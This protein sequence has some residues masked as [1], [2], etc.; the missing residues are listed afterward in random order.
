MSVEHVA[1]SLKP[2]IVSEN[3][4]YVPVIPPPEPL[5][6]KG[7]ISM[8]E[9]SLLSPINKY[10]EEVTQPITHS[11][12]IDGDDMFS[13]DSILLERVDTLTGQI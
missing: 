8:M 10:F 12:S 2:L 4:F 11:V 3:I 5:L 6:L 7:N 13:Y 9:L 1:I